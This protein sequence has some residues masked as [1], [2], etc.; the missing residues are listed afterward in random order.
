[1]NESFIW[2]FVGYALCLFNTWIINSYREKPSQG[3]KITRRGIF[4]V[5][6][7]DNEP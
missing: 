1:M 7:K 2:F 4:T 3:F 6:E 5:Y